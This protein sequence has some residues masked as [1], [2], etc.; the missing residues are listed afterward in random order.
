MAT[1]QVMKNFSPEQE[2]TFRSYLFTNPH[3]NIS[4]VFPQSLVA[5]EEL[6][7]LMSAISRTHR[8][9]QDRVLQFVDREKT[10]QAH[11]MLP[12]L[13]PLMNIFRLPDGRLNVSRKASFFNREFAILH[14]HGSIKEGTNVFGHVEHISDKAGK[15]ITGH[16][17]NHPQ[18]KSTRY[19][20]YGKT[21]DL[22]L[23]DEDLLSLPNAPEVIEHVSWLNQRYLVVSDELRDQ[24]FAHADTKEIVTYLSRPENVEAVVQK[25]VVGRKLVDHEFDPSEKDIEK[26]RESIR[27]G[28]QDEGV[29]RDLGKFVLD[30]SRGYLSAATKTSLVF[31]S[32][33][34]T[35]E[36]I[37]T[38]LLS[39]LSIE[40]QRI[41]RELF[42][43]TKKIAPVLLGEKGHIGVDLWKVHNEQELRA[44]MEERF[45]N[46]PVKSH[47]KKMV[48]LLHPGNMEMY[49]DRFNAALVAFEYSDA[50]LVDI[51]AHLSDTDVKDILTRAHEHR[52]DH[53]VLHPAI[54]H[55]G[56]LFELTSGYQ[57]YRDMFR[58]RR[59]SRTTQLL[60]TRL[61]FETPEILKVFGITCSKVI[62]S[63]SGISIIL[64]SILQ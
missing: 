8:S 36:E 15:K 24:V 30:Y 9:T 42:H 33:A 29:L 34:R 37:T 20:S 56:L 63:L 31:S 51:M 49:S 43:E 26:Q 17:V 28:L 50:S 39:S 40:E 41:G 16:P 1:E 23:T 25:W 57:A 3:G 62:S 12:L 11:A 60:T 27:Q 61:G 7:P 4:L 10:E 52:S 38:E 13:Q 35:L 14:G 5:G 18:V 19:I 55:G 47:G 59:G 46:I 21:L 2:E 53:D 64:F 44:Y 45:G 54:A 58:H 22:S 6:S 32:D 48:N